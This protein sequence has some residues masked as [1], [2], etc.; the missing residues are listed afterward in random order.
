MVASTAIL[1]NVLFVGNQSTGQAGVIFLLSSGDQPRLSNVAFVD[2]VA[3]TGGGAIMD[4]RPNYLT[5][6]QVANAI[7]WNNTPSDVYK[8]RSSDF[9]IDNSLLAGGCP[10]FAT[11][12]GQLISS[13]PLFV[14]LPNIGADMNWVTPDDVYG[15]L[16][17]QELS[18]ALD[19]G[20]NGLIGLD[21]A[22]LNHNGILT[23]TIPLDLDGLPRRI[24]A[25]AADSG[26]GSPP[27]VD[28]GAY[29]CQTCAAPTAT[30][31]STNDVNTYRIPR[32]SLTIL[33]CLIVGV[34]IKRYRGQSQ[35]RLRLV[36]VGA[37]TEKNLFATNGTINGVG[38][39]TD[40]HGDI[41]SL[42]RPI[43]V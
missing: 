1:N 43:S 30:T 38:R 26:I 34:S 4:D 27:L 19:A 6:T 11:C 28:L 3:G 42:H 5:G 9:F 31:V 39:A 15:D 32:T 23:E 40:A 16:R 12:C 21:S 18:P 33:L 2:N 29:E 24:D 36:T 41:G 25:E 10:T 13:N 8:S 7:F 17:L 22:G 35:L 20:N 14:Q 37:N